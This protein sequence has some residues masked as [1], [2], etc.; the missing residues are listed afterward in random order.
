MLKVTGR[1]PAF[2]ELITQGK[3]YEN[4]EPWT[5]CSF[6]RCSQTLQCCSYFLYSPLAV[7]FSFFS[8]PFKIIFVLQISTSLPPSQRGFPASHLPGM[9]LQL[10]QCSLLLLGQQ[11][12]SYFILLLF[13]CAP[14]SN[15]TILFPSIFY[16]LEV[17]NFAQSRY[18]I[19]T[20]L[21]RPLGQREPVFEP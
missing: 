14:D 13:C 5:S 3:G 8:L 10:L 4:N 15:G 19:R 7:S 9:P 1:V 11:R 21:H 17:Q 2:S 16:A 20:L 12:L 6:I 18:L